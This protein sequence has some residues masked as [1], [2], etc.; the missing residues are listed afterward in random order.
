[1]TIPVYVIALKTSED[2]RKAMAERLDH[3]GLAFQFI[4]AIHGASL[5]QDQ[6]DSALSASRQYHHASPMSKGAI[7]GYMSHMAA[8]QTIADNDAEMALVLEDDAFLH[9]DIHE[10][11]GRITRLKDK[12]D[13][14]NLHFRGGRTL[15]DVAQLSPQHR[16]T[17]CRYN[18]IGAESYIITK[19]AALHL[20]DHAKP[21]I[22]E[23][24]LLINRWWDHGL[25]ILTINPPVAH[26]DDS[27]TTIGYPSQN[28]AWP[29]DNGYYRFR[30]RLSRIMDS[31]TKRRMYPSMVATMKMRLMGV[32]P[33]DVGNN[34]Q[35]PDLIKQTDE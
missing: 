20:L 2:R 32:D 25:H 7:G 11:L 8:W 18:S 16:L 5:P 30:R 17:S 29:N 26:E 9:D 3:H 34:P 13:I 24:D 14:V 1:M 6:I 27:P 31:F 4:D 22:H 28:P 10:I 19:K 15:I 23:V 12:V 33:N 21:I 35:F